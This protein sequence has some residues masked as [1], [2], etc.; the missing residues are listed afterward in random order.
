MHILWLKNSSNRLVFPLLP[1]SNM[2]RPLELL[3]VVPLVFFVQDIDL[4]PLACAYARARGADRMSSFGDWIA[5]SAVCDLATAKIISR[6]VSD[7]VIAPGYTAE[8]LQ[9]LLKKKAG[10]YT[11]LEIDP[12]YEPPEMEKRHVYGITLEQ[13]R[14]NVLLKGSDFTNIVTGSQ[15]ID[16]EK[17]RDLIV[18]TIA[19]K[20]T[21]SN[22][23]CYAKNGQVV[24]LGAGQQSRIHW[25]LYII[26]H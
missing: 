1:L 8:A 25:Y 12:A 2:S 20:Y 26:K 3:L 24:G 7:G 17:V 14:N 9:L 15:S 5:L 13:K 4:T 6:E 16:A 18:A 19:L 10:K 11:V 22:S 23:V 21:Q